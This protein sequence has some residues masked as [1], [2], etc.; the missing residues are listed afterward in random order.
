[1]QQDNE[2]V[3]EPPKPKGAR[4]SKCRF[5]GRPADGDAIDAFLTKTRR[6]WPLCAGETESWRLCDQGS[7]GYAFEDHSCER[8]KVLT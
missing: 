6:N 7:I 8:F 5:W 3:I 4:C 2:V 1:M